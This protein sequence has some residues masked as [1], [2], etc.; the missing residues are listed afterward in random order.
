MNTAQP[1]VRAPAKV[2]QL[3]PGWGVPAPAPAPGVTHPNNVSQN[4]NSFLCAHPRVTDTFLSFLFFLLKINKTLA[5]VQVY[6][7]G[8]DLLLCMRSQEKNKI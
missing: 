1:P 5:G 6:R 4:T 8:F 7:I 2:T 3:P